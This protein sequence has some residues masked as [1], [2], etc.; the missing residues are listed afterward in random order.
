MVV[1][2][3][4]EI[5]DYIQESE[6]DENLKN[7]LVES[8]LL[9]FRRFKEEYSYYSGD[10]DKILNK[11]INVIEWSLILLKLRILGNLGTL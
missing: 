7:F 5:L 4:K 1:K 6:Y 8:I 10:Y 3:N 11:Y 2:I 9:E